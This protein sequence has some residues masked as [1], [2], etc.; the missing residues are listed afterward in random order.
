[1]AGRIGVEPGREN[2]NQN[3]PDYA[4]DPE[5]SPY[6]ADEEPADGADPTEN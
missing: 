4:K 3:S 6:P 5:D 2:Q 1:M